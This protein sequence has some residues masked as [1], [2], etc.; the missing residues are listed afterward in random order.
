MITP[1]FSLGQLVATAS[2]SSYMD[3]DLSFRSFIF[4]CIARHRAGDWGDVSHEDRS[5]NDFS[6][7]T[8]HHLVSVYRCSSEHAFY[9]DRIFIITEADRSVTTVLWSGEY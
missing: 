7:V 6:V 8:D 1:I 2:V 9:T 5:L 3:S 4:D